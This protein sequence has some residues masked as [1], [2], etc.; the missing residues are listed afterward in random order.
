MDGWL[1]R[2]ITLNPN[3]LRK[4]RSLLVVADLA[5]EFHKESRV[6][7]GSGAQ[8]PGGTEGRGVLLSEGD[9]VGS[10]QALRPHGVRG[11]LGPLK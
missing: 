11:G 7:S 10:W 8:C 2:C 1:T 9:S 6:G 4:E 3:V 5:L